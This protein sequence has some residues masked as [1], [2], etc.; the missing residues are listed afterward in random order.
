MVSSRATDCSAVSTAQHAQT[1]QLDIDRSRR[2]D[3]RAQG[4]HRGRP[5]LHGGSAATPTGARAGTGLGAV[6]TGAFQQSVV[7]VEQDRRLPVQTC[8]R[9][10]TAAAAAAAAAVARPASRLQTACR[11]WPGSHR[12]S[13]AKPI[14]EGGNTTQ[15]QI[16]FLM[17]GSTEAG[18]AMARQPGGQAVSVVECIGWMRACLAPR[19]ASQ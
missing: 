5:H 19:S 6:V 17:P 15:R 10:D 12:A 16:H 11:E 4:Q 7:Q 2:V 3:H 13:A 18:S 9:R 14:S 1:H 8:A